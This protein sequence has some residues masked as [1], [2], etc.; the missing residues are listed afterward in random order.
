MPARRSR[1]A[2]R[3]PT[4]T[5]NSYWAPITGRVNFWR[6]ARRAS[7]RQRST[8]R[9]PSGSNCPR[10]FRPT[11]LSG[12]ISGR[13]GPSGRW[14]SQPVWAAPDCRTGVPS[15]SPCTAH[16]SWPRG[17]ETSPGRALTPPWS[18]SAKAACSP[19]RAREPRRSPPSRTAQRS[20]RFRYGSRREPMYTFCWDSPI[21]PAPTIRWPK[22]WTFPFPP[23]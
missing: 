16:S 21:C 4:G 17:P 1:P 12:P 7:P 14:L 11:A 2:D 20:P 22:A 13:K 6:Q 9:L 18:P 23:T 19:R 3:C 8:R 10:D 15:A 5:R